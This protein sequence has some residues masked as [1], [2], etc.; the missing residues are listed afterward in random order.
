MSLSLSICQC[1]ISHIKSR[2]NLA[3][4]L[5]LCV[6]YVSLCVCKVVEVVFVEVPL[7]CRVIDAKE[8]ASRLVSA[9][10]RALDLTGSTFESL[11]I[12]DLEPFQIG[13]STP[14]VVDS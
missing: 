3:V 1:H 6:F 13:R 12:C 14:S 4:C 9:V 7:G 11:C 8:V 10:L 5:S 2:C